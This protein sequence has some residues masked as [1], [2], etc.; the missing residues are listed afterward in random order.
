[1]SYL[2]Q[3]DI[4]TDEEFFEYRLTL[5]EALFDRMFD[6]NVIGY[7]RV[8]PDDGIDCL[9]TSK[10]FFAAVATYHNYGVILVALNKFSTTYDADFFT[11]RPGKKIYLSNRPFY[12][13][14]RI[15]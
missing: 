8:I 12:M 6:K 4:M 11:I 2:Q 7:L 1:M 13:T 5:S 10:G 3:A 9:E 14:V 15:Q